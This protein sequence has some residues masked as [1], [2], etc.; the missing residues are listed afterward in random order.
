MA[1]A[2]RTQLA[3]GLGGAIG[4]HYV[5][6]RNQLYF[7]EFNGKVSVIDLIQALDTTVYS[8]TI[9]MP[10]NSSLDL[11]N[12]TSIQGGHIR[13]DHVHPA[14]ARVLRPQGNCALAYLGAAN[15]DSITHADLQ[16]LKYSADSIYGNDDSGNQLVNG[17]VFAVYNR[18]VQPA[19]NFD[20]A[21]VQV[22]QYGADIKVRWVTYRLKPRYRV[23]GT[24]YNQPEDI[25]VTEDGRYAYVTERSGNLVKVDLTNANRS[26]ATVIASGMMAPHQISLDE[27]R[28]QAY[29]VEFAAAGSSRL[30]RVDLTSGAKTAVVSNLD[31]AIGLLTTSDFGIAYVT[32]G[33]RLVRINLTTGQRELLA[34]TFTA[35]FFMTWNDA[36]ESAILIAERDPVNRVSLIDLTRSPIAATPIVNAV[37]FRPS[38]VAVT[39]PNRILVCSDQEINQYDLTASIFGSVGTMLLGI[40]HVPKTSIQ[41]GYATTDPGYF[42]QVKDAPFGGTLPLMFNYDKAR[43][44]GAQFYQI[45]VDGTP[46]TQPWSDYKWNASLNR[47]VITAV[48]PQNTSFFRIRNAGEL[49]YNAFLSY[50]LDTTILSDRLHTISVKVFTAPNAATEIV[51][52][53][54]SVLVRIDNQLPRA[55]IETIYYYPNAA[56]PADRREVGTCGI[57]EGTN[58]EFSFAIEAIDPQAQ[59][60]L[61]WSLGVL[62][63]DN[64]SAAINAD[65]YANH[66]SPTRQWSGVQGEVSAPGG[67]WRATVAGDPTSRRCA[68]TFYLYVWDR[69]INGWQ[70]IH[71]AT[72]TK[73]ITLLLS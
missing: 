20:Y 7:V 10:A 26:A 9:V 47:F 64:K 2:T 22:L 32:Q 72:Y 29:I 31:A 5:R 51:A 18:S 50:F 55:R 4:S 61:S 69:T 36:S 70:Y 39:A 65:T 49:W 58:D 52:G 28:S 30:L 23:L 21:K 15:F 57:V 34:P 13:W 35:P 19:A 17:R 43:S 38:S 67:R 11:T 33:N 63:G 53:Q 24:G 46:Q 12:G 45:L 71:Q 40:G 37:P 6:N 14:S 68:H 16:N 48:N 56:N 27:D 41:D 1:I 44:L 8:G 73:S 62:W 59:H 66:V 25:V 42:F 60:L 54:D 3:T